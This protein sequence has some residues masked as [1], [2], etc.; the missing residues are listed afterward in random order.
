MP[1]PKWKCFDLE[2]QGQKL[3]KPYYLITW[4]NKFF[5][6][7]EDYQVFVWYKKIY[8]YTGNVIEKIV[9]V[10]GLLNYFQTFSIPSK[11]I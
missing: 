11:K 3:L 4:V 7:G 8:M 6:L 5:S 10:S 1:L 2:N 9:R